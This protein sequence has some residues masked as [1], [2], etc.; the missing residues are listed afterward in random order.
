[1]DI[2]R[3]FLQDIERHGGYTGFCSLGVKFQPMESPSLRSYKQ[4][5]DGRS[6]ILV[7]KVDPL[8]PANDVLR[9]GDVLMAVDGIDLANDGTIPFRKGERVEV[10][11]C[12]GAYTGIHRVPPP[13]LDS[14]RLI[15]S[16]IIA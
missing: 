11:G 8:A 2:L 10:R 16:N 7:T 6:G 13:P 3:H 4:L 5:P 15:S 12:V 9:R 1:M 14:A